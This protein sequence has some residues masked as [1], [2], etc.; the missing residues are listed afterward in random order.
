MQT[1]KPSPSSSA[2]NA[3]T[4]TRRELQVVCLLAQGNTD[5]QVAGKLKIRVNTA[6]THHRNILS[7]TGQHNSGALTLYAM[8]I[9][10]ITPSSI[11]PK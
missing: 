8:N 7:K 6:R 5:K 11:L 9:G 10:L 2:E 4:L 1:F 3:A